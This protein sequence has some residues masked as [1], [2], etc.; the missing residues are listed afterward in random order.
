M[1]NQSSSMPSKLI[2]AL[3]ELADKHRLELSTGAGEK[4]QG[5][6]VEFLR[7]GASAS[8]SPIDLQA[9]LIALV[10]R[11]VNALVSSMHH[12]GPCRNCSMRVASMLATEIIRDA[13][14]L[15]EHQHTGGIH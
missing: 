5:A 12:G 6:L 15:S 2:L 13:E 7:D 10:P 4:L 14:A 1:T 3:A 9:D 8:S 11:F